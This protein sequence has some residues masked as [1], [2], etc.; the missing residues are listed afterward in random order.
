MSQPKVMR[1]FKDGTA[2]VSLRGLRRIVSQP[3]NHTLVDFVRVA[4]AIR[5][6]ETH[7]ACHP[8]GDRWAEA[9]T[10]RE[11]YRRSRR[12]RKASVVA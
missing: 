8:N 3:G 9:I 2:I 7:N 1:V 12:Q 5:C 4:T 11:V 10:Y 6:I